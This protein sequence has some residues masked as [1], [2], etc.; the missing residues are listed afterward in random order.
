MSSQFRDIVVFTTLY[1]FLSLVPFLVLNQAVISAVRDRLGSVDVVAVAVVGTLGLVALTALVLA[2]EGVSRYN[3]FLV[4]PTDALSVLVALSFLFAASSWWLV[5][6][7]LFRFGPDLS[8]DVLLI[9]LLFCQ[10]PMIL[11]LSLLTALGNV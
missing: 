9:V 7:L 2:S 4:A 8:F 6:E 3:Q 10:I 5:P 1:L 11:F